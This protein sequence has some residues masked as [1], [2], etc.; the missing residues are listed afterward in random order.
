MNL[1]LPFNG[2]T[3]MSHYKF[4]LLWAK[5][6]TRSHA[7]VTLGLVQHLL[8]TRQQYSGARDFSSSLAAEHNV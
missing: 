1:P 7:N 5:G 2:E 6:A 4:T 8:R 3:R